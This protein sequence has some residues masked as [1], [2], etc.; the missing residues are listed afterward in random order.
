MQFRAIG[1][2]GVPRALEQLYQAYVMTVID[3]RP[4]LVAET[5]FL[6]FTEGAA[7]L[8]AATMPHRG[9]L[10]D[11]AEEPFI[12]AWHPWVAKALKTVTGD[13]P[14]DTMRIVGACHR[15]GLTLAQTRWAV[16]SRKDLAEH[17]ADRDDD[18]VGRCWHRCETENP[19]SKKTDTGEEPQ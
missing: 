10:L 11:T 1:R 19:Q 6:R 15:S 5:E 4:T 17:H 7:A 14:G 13:L 12:L 18:D 9:G 2:T 3:S 8:V 16:N